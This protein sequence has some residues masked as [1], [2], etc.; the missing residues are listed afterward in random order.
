MAG[1]TATTPDLWLKPDVGVFNDDAGTIPAG[2][3]DGVA[4]WAD[5]SGNGNDCTQTTSA[6]RP[7]YQSNIINSLPAISFD[8]GNEYMDCPY[9]GEI[10][11]II[12]VYR[13]STNNDYKTLLGGDTSDAVAVGS[14]YFQAGQGGSP[15]R[16]AA[17]S[18][19]TTADTSAAGDMEA[20]AQGQIGV[21][22]IQAGRHDGSSIRIF[23]WKHEIHSDSKSC[24]ETLRPINAAVVG[25]GYYSSSITD[26]F[27]GQLC[28]LLVY[29]ADLSDSEY[30][31]VINY[32]E[33]KYDLAPRSSRYVLSTFLS[34][35]ERLYL[36]T[37][38]D[39]VTFRI[40][41]SSYK[42]PANLV[43]D[44][45]VIFQNGTY[46]LAY[47]INSAGNETTQ[48]S[49]ATSTDL[50]TWE[51]VDD[52]DVSAI[53]GSTPNR[54]CWAP[55]FFIDPEDNDQLKVIFSY[56]TDAGANFT[57]YVIVPASA[58]LTSW[59]VPTVMSG[60]PSATGES[61]DHYIVYV[62]DQSDGPYFDFFKD[63]GGAGDN[64]LVVYEAA[65]LTGTYAAH[66][67]GDWA[68]WGLNLYEGPSV[69]E[70]NGVW[71]VYMDDYQTP[72][73][74][75]YSDEQA[76]NWAGTGFTNWSAPAHITLEDF[77]SAQQERHGTIFRRASDRAGSLALL[78]VG[79]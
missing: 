43:R 32:L 54:R 53:G 71:R 13:S 47:T 6:D 30:N 68:T 40:A 17:F 4:V 77:D 33:E 18:R 74:I 55:E 67:T 56:S 73:G 62:P 69:F 50:V 76:G 59:G 14:Y 29:S 61:I 70:I 38:D 65:A 52:V 24:G 5:Q 7:E 21:W 2:N 45:S 26:F 25:G 79:R 16:L 63:N 57:G 66:R 19:C 22:Q 28:E 20:T 36:F 64:Y 72:D 11:C 27:D 49:V 37:S 10:Q 48:F 8:G 51:H 41:P 58:D 9:T 60:I 1:P 39:G 34:N 42:L 75:H 46:W 12:A 44:P 31:Q 35:D 3:G 78:G 15:G 23:K